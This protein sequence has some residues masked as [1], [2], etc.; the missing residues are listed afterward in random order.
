MKLSNDIGRRLKLH[1]LH[2]FLAVAEAGSMSKAAAILHTTQPAVSRSIAQLENMFGVRLLERNAHGVEPTPYGRALLEC[3]VAVFD[4]L[5]QGVSKI[6]F[7]ADPTAGT[8]RIGSHHFL[9]SSFVSAV[10][11]RLS[12]RYNRI[13]FHVIAG[14]TDTL[15]RE[16]Q[17]RKF[18]LLIAWKSGDIP[19]EQ[20]GFEH[21]YDDHHV[22]AVGAKSPWSRRRNVSLAQLVTER[23]TLPPADSVLGLAAMA[24]FRASGLYYPRAT[25]FS[26]PTEARLGLLAT[27]RFLTI[28]STSILTFPTKRA[29]IIALPVELPIAS[30]P[31]GIITVKNRNLSP[32]AELFIATAREVAG[33]LEKR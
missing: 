22:V 21:L 16:L 6:E 10:I 32:A 2:V 15:Y 29:D 8:V 24:A 4:D 9:A 28:L 1:D 25:M 12:R 13:A 11:D 30:M 19:D 31:I 7:L 26:V 20:L 27:G 17:E 3:G 23:W 18:D 33:L 5:S 14:Q